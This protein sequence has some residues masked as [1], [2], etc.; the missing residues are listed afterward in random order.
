M[1]TLRTTRELFR[2]EHGPFPSR[3][4]AWDLSL[5][6]GVTPPG[7]ADSLERLNQLRLVVAFPSDRA[8][9]AP[10]FRLDRTH[11]LVEPLTRLFEAERAV[12]RRSST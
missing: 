3:Q 10:S 5:W 7:S 6:S 4:R 8:G 1:A 2:Q 11:P 12:C 9:Q